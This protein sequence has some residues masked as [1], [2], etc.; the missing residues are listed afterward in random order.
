MPSQSYYARPAAELTP[1]QAAL[2]P[3]GTLVFTST[4]SEQANWSATPSIET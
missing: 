4:T 2:A 3:G 1:K